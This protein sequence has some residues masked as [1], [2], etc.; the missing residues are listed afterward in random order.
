MENRPKI[1]SLLKD[2]GYYVK[3]N[4][5]RALSEIT[6]EIVEKLRPVVLATYYNTPQE[7]EFVRRLEK[8]KGWVLIDVQNIISGHTARGTPAGKAIKSASGKP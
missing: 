5:V 6:R 3:I 4:A 7:E 1:L 2:K 8:E